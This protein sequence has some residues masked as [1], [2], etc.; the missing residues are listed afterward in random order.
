MHTPH[1]DLRIEELR[2]EHD[3]EVL[4]DL[5]VGDAEPA[6]LRLVVRE[7]EQLL[8]IFD[9]YIALLPRIG[10]DCRPLRAESSG[11]RPGKC[12]TS[13]GNLS[14]NRNLQ[15]RRPVAVVSYIVAP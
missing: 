13:A 14:G 10:V 3:E 15:H 8:L 7:L 1:T 6:K 9:R 12:P 4:L 11:R 2:F 5:R